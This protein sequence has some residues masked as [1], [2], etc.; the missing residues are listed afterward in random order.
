MASSQSNRNCVTKNV[1]ISKHV[2]RQL[3]C[4]FPKSNL[5][6]YAFILFELFS[7][8]SIKFD[9]IKC[10]LCIWISNLKID[11]TDLCINSTHIKIKQ[12]RFLKIRKKNLQNDH[13]ALTEKFS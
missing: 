12:N 2:I 1:E 8:D 6:S 13:S 7:F 10:N 5:F 11:K 3:Y 9:K 4:F